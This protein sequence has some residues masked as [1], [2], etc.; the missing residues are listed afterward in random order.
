MGLRT[1]YTSDIGATSVAQ[2]GRVG[3][4]AA[5]W[6][7]AAVIAGSVWARAV[8]AWAAVVAGGICGVVTILG[9]R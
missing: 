8:G 3:G 2:L 4:S 5:L 9:V 6:A 1:P 7:W